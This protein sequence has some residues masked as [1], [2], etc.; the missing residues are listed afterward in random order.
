MRTEET[1]DLLV[2]GGGVAGLTAAL[3]AAIEGL[4]VLV[5][6]KTEQLGGTAATSAGT[7]W[8]PGSSQSERAG[9]ADPVVRA[10]HYLAAEI[11][12]D[13]GADLRDTFLA[14]GP[15]VLDYLAQHSCVSFVPAARHPDYHDQHAGAAI[16]GRALVARAFD[17]RELGPD[18]ARVRPPMSHMMVLGGMSVSKDDIAPLLKPLASR[19]ALRHVVTLLSRHARD[20]LRHPRGTR[21]VMGNALIAR[22]LLSLRQRGVDPLMGVAVQQLHEDGGRVS[23]ATLSQGGR[24]WR[25]QARCGV[26]LACGG[27]GHAP[28]W[29]Q[30]LLPAPAQTQSLLFEGNTGDGLRLAQSVGAAIDETGHRTPAFWVPVSV[31]RQANGQEQRFPHFALDRA[32]PG[33][34]AVDASGRRFVNEGDSYHDFVLAMLNASPEPAVPAHL[35]CDAHFL[36]RYGLGLV[37]PGAWRLRPYLRAGYLKRAPTLA[38]LA[39]QLGVDPEGLRV[40]VSRHNGF[41]HT[42]VD[43]DYG[44]GTSE[45]N[46]FNGDPTHTPNPC[47]GPIATAPFY[48][49][50]VWPG[51]AGTSVGLR[52]DV[53]ARVLGRDGQAIEGLYAAGADM[54]S[55]MRG[56]YPGPGVTLGPA[57]VFAWR[58]VMHAV[59][60]R[61]ST[62][63]SSSRSST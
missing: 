36:H 23:G 26:V 13:S 17:G 37:R 4:S 9:L 11:D 18:F 42:G 41:A 60:R 47:I 49:V 27:F 38:A 28:E 16:G 24:T 53:D 62:Q 50:T 48:A 33:L 45:L 52:T 29:R 61:T 5:C 56:R 34:I 54:A 43:L 7:V 44:K 31:L 39:G 15:R 51:D 32:K 30:R 20:R 2:I 14:T 25:V 21:L 8:I 3:V 6:E 46:R 55:I 35:I 63:V 1:V 22:L 40:T 19:A 57:M 58:A 59:G 10:H 12:T